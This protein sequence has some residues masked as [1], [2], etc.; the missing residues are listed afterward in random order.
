MRS[1][2]AGAARVASEPVCRADEIFIN[3]FN[4]EIFL[5]NSVSRISG[6]EEPTT[7][8][9]LRGKNDESVDSS[10]IDLLIRPVC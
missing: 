6:D 5:L 9:E 4:S 1:A 10:I 8:E 3:F 7:R 2:A